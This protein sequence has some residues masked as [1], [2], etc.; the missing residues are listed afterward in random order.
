VIDAYHPVLQEEVL[1]R[2]AQAR[3]DK[4]ICDSPVTWLVHHVERF[5]VDDLNCLRPCRKVDLRLGSLCQRRYH[6][7]QERGLSVTHLTDRM[8]KMREGFSKSSFEPETVR[9]IECPSK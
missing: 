1:R 3:D 8:E 2:D 5:Q 4:R 6:S 9:I 7:F